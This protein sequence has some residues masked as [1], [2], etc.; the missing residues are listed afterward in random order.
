MGF[1]GH[2]LSLWTGVNEGVDLGWG[3]TF[4]AQSRYIWS[5]KCPWYR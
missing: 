5:N 1:E 2:L 3:E 4:V